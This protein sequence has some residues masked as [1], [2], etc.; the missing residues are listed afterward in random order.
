MERVWG[1]MKAPSSQ[2]A[3]SLRKTLKFGA[4]CV[5]ATSPSSTACPHLV[6]AAGRTAHKRQPHRLR[7][8]LPFR[9]RWIREAARIRLTQSLTGQGKQ[10]GSGQEL[11]SLVA[12]AGSRCSVARMALLHRL[13]LRRAGLALIFGLPLFIGHAVDGLAA[14]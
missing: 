12:P 1:S 11:V 5:K 6:V 3:R 9:D 7:F 2:R 8:S 13:H 4:P 14:L 10:N